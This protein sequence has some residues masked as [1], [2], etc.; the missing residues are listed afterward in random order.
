[1][2]IRVET[3]AIF[4]AKVV[5]LHAHLA[6]HFWRVR[7][8]FW[9]FFFSTFIFGLFFPVFGAV[10]MRFLWLRLLLPFHKSTALFR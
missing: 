9:R 2:H 10:K 6:G 5:Y 1:M 4:P 7:S 8:T 3:G